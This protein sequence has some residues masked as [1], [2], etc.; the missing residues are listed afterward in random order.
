[1]EEEYIYEVTDD[2]GVTQVVSKD[3]LDEIISNT[4][5]QVVDHETN[6]RG[7][8]LNPDELR[9]LEDQVLEEISHRITMRK[10]PKKEFHSSSVSAESIDEIFSCT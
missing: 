10:Q 4:L 5:E 7:Y 9:A 2:L 3:E 1:M 6:E 8:P